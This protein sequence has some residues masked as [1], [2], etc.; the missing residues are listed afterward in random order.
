M[1]R[2]TFLQTTGLMSAATL[3]SVP[4]CAEPAPKYKMGLQLFGVREDMAKDPI[5]TLKAVQAMG[6]EDFEVYGFDAEKVEIYGHKCAHF[7]TILDDLDLTATSGHFSFHPFLDKPADDLVRFTDQ[8]IAG[9]RA[10]GLPYITWPWMAPEQRTLETYKRLPEML[11][12]IGEQ[13]TAAGLGFTYHNHDFE[14][15][16]YDGV[17][18]YDIILEET[19]PKLVKLQMDMYWVMHSSKETP[20]ELIKRQPG[21]FVMWHI[22]DMHKVSRDYTELG[23]GSIDYVDILPD[24]VASGLEYYYLEQGGNFTHNPL[25]SAADSAAYFKEHL[26]RFL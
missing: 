5:G 25:R 6:Y 14:F 17:N 24:P 18:G 20:K 2:R 10:I 13:V 3:L 15:T 1:N 7:K 11:N 26:Q 19:D 23:N 12:G 4:S 21:R 16:D 9:A 8:C 22:K